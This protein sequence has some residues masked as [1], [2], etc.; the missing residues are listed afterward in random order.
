MKY[1]FKT[2]EEFVKEYGE[3]WQ[4]SLGK[5]FWIDSMNELFCQKFIL[6]EKQDEELKQ[7]QMFDLTILKQNNYPWYDL[8]YSCI[9]IT[10]CMITEDKPKIP[11]Y[12]PRK[13][14]R[15]I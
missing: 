1:R 11:S 3:K 2:K 10:S 4:T 8:K 5:A 14:D 13:L 12:E 7:Y 15:T 6:T 9:I